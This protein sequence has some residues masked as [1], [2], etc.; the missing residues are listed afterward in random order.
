M[1]SLWGGGGSGPGQHRPAPLVRS[2]SS[3]V[4]RLQ[5]E[6]PLR[7]GSA[8]GGEEL[9]QELA[10]HGHVP[11][12]VGEA[13]RVKLGT[14]RIS[15]RGLLVLVMA[16]S[17]LASSARRAEELWQDEQRVETS[18]RTLLVLAMAHSV[19]ARSWPTRGSVSFSSGHLWH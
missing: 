6:P 4:W 9:G 14:S 1:G 5:P 2:S 17:V 15:G 16:C 10:R 19:L 18:G 11:Q 8:Q 13:L 12:R 3:E 7:R